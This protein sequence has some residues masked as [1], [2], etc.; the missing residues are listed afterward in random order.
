MGRWARLWGRLTE[1]VCTGGPALGRDTRFTPD[2][3]YLRDLEIGFYRYAVRMSGELVDCIE[4]TLTGTMVDLG[5]GCGAYSMALCRRHP[6]LSSVIWE[7]A[8]VVPMAS[9]VVAERGMAD[10]VSV[11]ARDYTTE[12]YGTDLA[13][14]VMSNML[15]SERREVA[16]GMVARA[17]RAL[18]P[19]GRLVINNSLLNETRTGPPFSA[20]HNLSSVVLW[21][22]GRDFTHDEIARLVTDAGFSTPAEYPIVGG[23]AHVIVAT[24]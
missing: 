7:M 11:V 24:K 5:G 13:V 9:K 6:G 20:L 1:V 12:E 10:R 18:A 14:V 21:D 17:Y 15:H 4:G 16:R 19:G 23:S 2:P 22:G 8:E 3:A